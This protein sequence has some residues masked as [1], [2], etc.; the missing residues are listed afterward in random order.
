MLIELALSGKF[1][2][3]LVKRLIHDKVFRTLGFLVFVLVL[4]GT[5]FFWLV[6]GKT[7]LD[8]MHYAVGTLSMNSP[9]DGPVSV[10][11]KIFDMVYRIIG[12]GV[13]LTFI[14]EAGKTIVTAHHDFEKKQAEKKAL[15]AL[16][17]T[18]EIG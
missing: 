15:K 10:V 17:K 3:D 16:K 5:M 6:E 18:K 2:Y 13:F 7:F 11:G 9:A 4:I 1:I 14:L 12:V 8:G